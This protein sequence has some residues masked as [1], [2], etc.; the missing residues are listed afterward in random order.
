[1]RRVALACVV[2]VFGGCGSTDPAPQKPVENTTPTA[3]APVPSTK[4]RCAQL[5]DHLIDLEFAKAG[6]AA[7]T[8]EEQDALAS[9][10]ASIRESKQAEFL[11][12]CID[13]T[14]SARVDCALA[15]TDLAAVERCDH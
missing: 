15:A 1:M 7:R 6:A 4:E 10:K 3:H 13:K 2:L 12:T 8:H 14:P 5:F 9:Q 11:T